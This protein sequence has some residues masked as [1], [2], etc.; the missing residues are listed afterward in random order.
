MEPEPLPTRAE[1]EKQLRDEL[2]ALTQEVQRNPTKDS[3]LFDRMRE[4]LEKLKTLKGS[5]ESS[6]FS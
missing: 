4:I 2:R 3:P 1:L 6:G 5:N